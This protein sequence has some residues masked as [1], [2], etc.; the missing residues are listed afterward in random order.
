MVVFG[1]DEK[2]TEDWRKCHNEEL[3]NHKLNYS[4]KCNLTNT[5]RPDGSLNCND[6]NKTNI[7]EG[8]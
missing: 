8:C 7:V 6:V 2:A 5:I 3:I 1:P 4:E